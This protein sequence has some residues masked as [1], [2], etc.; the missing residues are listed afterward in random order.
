MPSAMTSAVDLSA[1][2]L[3]K[4]HSRLPPRRQ[5]QRVGRERAR[6]SPERPGDC[7]VRDMGRGPEVKA[8]S[9]IPA[10]RVPSF[11]S[12][13]T[14]RVVSRSLHA[15]RFSLGRAGSPWRTAVSS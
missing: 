5:W 2:A 9:A 12:P 3:A 15:R 10:G 4:L 8:L 11:E 7:P 1:V 13:R 6:L 14:P